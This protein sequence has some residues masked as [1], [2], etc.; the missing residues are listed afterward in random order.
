MPAAGWFEVEVSRKV[1]QAH[2]H[3]L[4]ST[5]SEKERHRAGGE[6][7]GTL[8]DKKVVEKDCPPLPQG[9]KCQTAGEAAWTR[10]QK[11]KKE[12]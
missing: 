10:R 2:S 4:C 8:G 9:N 6:T 1:S 11:E 3:S 12:K 7:R 5:S